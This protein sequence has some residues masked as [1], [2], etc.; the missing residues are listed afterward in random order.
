MREI[1]LVLYG[2]DDNTLIKVKVTDQEL[3]FLKELAL[4]SEKASEYKCQPTLH[5]RVPD[6]H[7]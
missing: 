4:L 5:V 2:C 1:E 3:D 7:A 6:E